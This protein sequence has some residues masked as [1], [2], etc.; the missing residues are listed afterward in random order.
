MTAFRKQQSM[1]IL[2]GG[3]TIIGAIVA[4]LFV[5]AVDSRN[6]IQAWAEVDD[7]IRDFSLLDPGDGANG[8]KA[9]SRL[10]ELSRTYPGLTVR[11]QAAESEWQNRAQ[12]FLLRQLEGISPGDIKSLE[13]WSETITGY[14]LRAEQVGVLD[15]RKNDWAEKSLK[16]L[17]TRIKGL[18]PGDWEGY[19]SDFPIRIRLAEIFPYT[20]DVVAR[21]ESEWALKTV[22]KT[23]SEAKSI[24]AA[25]PELA[26]TKYYQCRSLIV[27]LPTVSDN[28]K[29]PERP[30]KFLEHRRLLSEAILDSARWEIRP[31]IAV[32]RFAT[33]AELADRL[34]GT[35]EVEA[36]DSGTLPDWVRFR[37]GCEYLSR[38]A[39]MTEPPKDK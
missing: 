32:D 35:E 6:L 12:S 34:Y 18:Q 23:I 11:A 7:V 36:R 22:R 3:I 25:Q 31:M 29:R 33:V 16:Y 19:A 9:K 8:Q 17:T 30:D 37:E 28:Q 4:W 10:D 21:I 5:P 39:K 15:D 20:Q 24:I 38:L 1:G 26:R 2:L 13:S 27:R 14:P